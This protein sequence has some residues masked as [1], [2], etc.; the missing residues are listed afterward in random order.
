MAGPIWRFMMAFREP[1]LASDFTVWRSAVSRCG[2]SKIG[3][4][5]NGENYRN[6]CLPYPPERLFD[7]CSVACDLIFIKFYIKCPAVRIEG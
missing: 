4:K 6:A 1:R 7:H 3:L 5:L 2:W